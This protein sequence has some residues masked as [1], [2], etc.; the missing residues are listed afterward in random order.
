[1]LLTELAVNI[2]PVVLLILLSFAAASS[3]SSSL[4]AVSPWFCRG[5]PCPSYKIESKGQVSLAWCTVHADSD[6]HEGIDM[7]CA[8]TG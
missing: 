1:M 2:K 5:S 6:A 4:S 7:Q 8:E 3:S